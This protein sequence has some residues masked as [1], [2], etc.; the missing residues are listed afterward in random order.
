MGVPVYLLFCSGERGTSCPG[1]SKFLSRQA[2]EEDF[3]QDQAVPPPERTVGPKAG[4]GPGTRSWGTPK[5][6][7][8]DQRP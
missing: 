7:T 4:K 2:L 3:S 6:S 8:C 1:W 5:E